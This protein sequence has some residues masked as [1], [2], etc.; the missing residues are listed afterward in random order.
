MG[1]FRGSE[2]TGS[3][4]VRGVHLLVP[5]MKWLHAYAT[6]NPSNLDMHVVTLRFNQ[7]TVYQ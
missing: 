7:A 2:L 6:I 1:R 3:L 5:N 4:H